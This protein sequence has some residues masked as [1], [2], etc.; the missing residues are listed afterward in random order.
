MPSKIGCRRGAKEGGGEDAE[1]EEK[2][3][4]LLK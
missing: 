3:V 1:G 2:S 4:P